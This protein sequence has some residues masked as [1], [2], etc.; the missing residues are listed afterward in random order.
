MVSWLFIGVMVALFY[1][2]NHLL[3]KKAAE[4][5]DSVYVIYSMMLFIAIISLPIALIF[6]NRIILPA[7]LLW[8]FLLTSLMITIG[9]IL[10]TKSI[11]HSQIGKTVP[12]LALT[13]LVAMIVA[14]FA[15]GEKPNTTGILGVI[16]T[17]FGV[18]VLKIAHFG[19]KNLLEPFKN[20]IKNKGSRY[21]LIVS[22]LYGIEHVIDKYIITNSNVFTRIIPYSYFV[23]LMMTVY[24][25]VMDKRTFS[26]KLKNAFRKEKLWII[27][28]ATGYTGEVIF[29]A[30]G[31][32][33]TLVT[34]MVA[35]KRAGIIFSVI[36]AHYL[37]KEK[38]HF[39]HHLMGA[40]FLVA[41]AIL[42]SLQ[43]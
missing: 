38:K 35:I 31:L 33:M 17:V 39:L 42:V 34:Y 29:T 20:I 5:A 36:F 11:K 9:L 8:W 1:A 25:L 18:Y 43:L 40:A 3:D 4:K 6:K 16:L 23:V 41:G 14:L 27:L 21:M 30:I 15:L 12:L 37:L 28:F 2:I 7:H 13:P 10:F 19:K 24:L 32:S 22:V 26:R